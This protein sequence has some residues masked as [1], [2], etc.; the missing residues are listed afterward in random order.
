MK[1]SNWRLPTPLIM[2]LLLLRPITMIHWCSVTVTLSPMWQTWLLSQLNPFTNETIWLWVTEQP[3]FLTHA[4]THACMHTHTQT[5]IHFM[6]LWTLSGITW[7]SWYQNQSGF[8]WS[9][10]QWVT[11]ASAG[12]YANLHLAP[13]RLPRLH[14]TT[15]FFT[16]RM[17]FLLPNQQR[18]STVY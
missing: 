13:D 2:L 8:Y 17:P 16:G 15:Q 4:C 6:T 18:Q 11:V 12:P 7:V 5:L 9:K 3:V 1:L 14:S 10:S